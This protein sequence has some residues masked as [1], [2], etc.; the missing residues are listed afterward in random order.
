[1]NHKTSLALCYLLISLFC[2]NV[3][4]LEQELNLNETDSV[5]VVKGDV[6]SG[7]DTPLAFQEQTLTGTYGAV[8]IFQDGAYDYVSNAAHDVLAEGA[9]YSEEKVLVSASNPARACCFGT[10]RLD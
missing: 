9:K 5:L 1:M 10:K 7:L 8:K 3:Q 4:A 6:N 2:F